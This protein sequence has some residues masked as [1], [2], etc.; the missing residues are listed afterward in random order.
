MVIGFSVVTVSIGLLANL[1]AG[2]QISHTEAYFGITTYIM[3]HLPDV[4]LVAVFFV[5]GN[6][7]ALRS[8][9]INHHL[10]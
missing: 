7:F 6:G 3:D 10:P 4:L 5:V 2:F 1:L 8:M 9:M